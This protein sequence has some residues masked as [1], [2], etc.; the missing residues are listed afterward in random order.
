MV[1]AY[2][3]FQKWYWF[4]KYSYMYHSTMNKDKLNL[5]H[6]FFFFLNI[7]MISSSL[8][9]PTSLSVTLSVC[10]SVSLVFSVC[11]F[12]NIHSIKID[13]PLGY[14]PH[15]LRNLRIT[16]TWM[17][18]IIY[19]QSLHN[20]I[21]QRPLHMICT[22]QSSPQYVTIRHLIL[23]TLNPFWQEIDVDIEQLLHW[24]AL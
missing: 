20:D 6:I 9:L 7:K 4:L 13:L 22:E 3:Y 12:Q 23:G 17:S 24:C 5:Q 15:I 2:I 21:H 19:R 10:L 11:Q 18:E 8:S 1:H 16:G 14:P